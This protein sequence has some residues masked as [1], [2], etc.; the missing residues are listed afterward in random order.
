VHRLFFRNF[1]NVTTVGDI[2]A[3]LEEALEAIISR[4]PVRSYVL[5]GTIFESI[6]GSLG[7]LKGCLFSSSVLSGEPAENTRAVCDITL[8][9]LQ[10]TAL[11]FDT[12]PVEELEIIGMLESR[13]ISFDRVIVLDV[14]EGVLPGPREVS[15]VIPPVSLK[16]WASHPPICGGDIQV[17]LLPSHGKRRGGPSHI[18]QFRGQAAKQIHRGDPLGGGEKAGTA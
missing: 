1:E 15:P 5:S 2:A 6:F 18:P 9:H 11:P 7:L 10:S 4:T 17:Q 8:H 3:A 16:R 14:N 12:H 13:N